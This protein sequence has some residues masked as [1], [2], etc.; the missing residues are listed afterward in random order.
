MKPIA[1]AYKD[2]PILT[3]TH[4][5]KRIAYLDSGATTQIPVPVMKALETHM[6]NHN[7]NPHRGAHVL[8]MEASEAYEGAR[9]VVQRFINARKRE[10]IIFTRNTTENRHHYSRAS[11]KSC[12]LAICMP[13]DRGHFGIYVPR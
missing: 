2:F 13:S 9:D 10:E 3:R 4:R 11:C 5:G 1:E 6:A 7:G 12:D 8:A